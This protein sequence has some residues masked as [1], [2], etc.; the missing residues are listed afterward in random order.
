MATQEQELT[1]ILPK[2]RRILYRVV[3]GQKLMDIA[4]ETGIS[5]NTLMLIIHRPAF[6]EE[7]EQVSK[8]VDKRLIKKLADP[9]Q[10]LN[11]KAIKAAKNL[12]N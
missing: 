1:G 4:R 10:Y 9:Q 8:Q 7:V 3:C 2:H 12:C 11:Q 6:E 5:Y